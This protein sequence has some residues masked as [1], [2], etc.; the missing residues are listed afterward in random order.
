MRVALFTDTYTPEINGVVSSIVTLQEGLEAM[1]HDVFIVTT[2]ASIISISYENR[3]LRLPGIQLKQMYGY[4]LT[5]PLHIRAYDIVKEMNPD[6]LHAHTEFGIGIFARIVARLMHKPLVVTYHTTYEDYTHYVN[7]LKSKTFEKLAKRTVS[8]LSKLYIETSDG[9]ISP[10]DKTKSMLQGYGI[11]REINVIPTG[12][13]LDRFKIENVNKSEVSRLKSEY[14][15]VDKLTILYVG[16]I[17]KEKSIDLVIEGFS[18]IDQSKI[19]SRLVI[20]GAG[21][22][23]DELKELANKITDEGTVLFLGKKAA[24]TIPIYYHA[25]D[26][27]VSASLT[28][29]QGMTFIEALASGKVVFAREDS[30]LLDLI[31]P[32]KNGYFFTDAKDFSLKIEEYSKLSQIG[33]DNIREN[34]LSSSLPYDR[35]VFINSVLNVYQNAITQVEESMILKSVQHKNDVVECEFENKN[36]SLKIVVSS[37]MFVKLGL[38]KGNE[39]SRETIEELLEHE[40]AVKAYQSCIR[41]ISTKDRSRKEMYDYLIENTTLD[42]GQIN[43]IIEHLETRKY[44]DDEAFAKDTVTSL[45]ALL[46]GKQK[47]IQTLRKKG[48]S[49][50]I[51]DR[52]IQTDMIENEVENALT[53]AEKVKPNIKDKSVR[54]K[55]QKLTQK[56]MTQG[57]DFNVIELVMR[58]L[59]FTED[60]KGELDVLRKAALKAKRKYASKFNGTGLRNAVF[61]YLDHQGFNLD[62]IYIILNEME[63]DDE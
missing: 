30:V 25:C 34:A 58:S 21:P 7:V 16:R 9:A 35:E 59:N 45:Q 20:V 63:W 48:I 61:S 62:D 36:R 46:Q 43:L 12:L 1:G 51:I 50:E 60:E 31:I 52:V 37:E 32:G 47:I 44:I 56:L 39:L 55:K 6:I 3:V 28:E 14:D 33:K 10:S 11:K 22:Q 27:F 2:H 41:K 40:Q 42:I 13:N 17:A 18:K 23:E 26:I 15:L 29:T 53:L 49:Q 19:P 4:V 57:F 24:H 8:Q 54:L 5:S 38:R